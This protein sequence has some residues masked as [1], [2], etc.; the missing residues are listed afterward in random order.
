MEGKAYQ[1]TNLFALHEKYYANK[2]YDELLADIKKLGPAGLLNKYNKE[3][4]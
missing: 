3:K 1:M 4:L 2:C